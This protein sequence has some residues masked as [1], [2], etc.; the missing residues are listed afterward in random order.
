LVI[1]WL[2]WTRR[3]KRRGSKLEQKL[4]AATRAEYYGKPEQYAVLSPIHELEHYFNGS[5]NPADLAESGE[6]R[7]ELI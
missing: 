5:Y 3:Q 4:T 2:F 6:T 7:K 1:G